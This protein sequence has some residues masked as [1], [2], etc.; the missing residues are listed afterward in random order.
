MW[1]EGRKEA[2]GTYGFVQEQ[3]VTGQVVSTEQTSQDA[4]GA[5]E[6]IHLYVLIEGE[7]FFYPLSGLLKLCRK[8]I[9]NI[10]L[11]SLY[12]FLEFAFNVFSH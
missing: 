7:I 2:P 9:N 1:V 11:I 3:L 6:Q 12:L 4:D 8:K 5:L 10:I